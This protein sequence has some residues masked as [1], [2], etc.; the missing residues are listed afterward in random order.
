MEWPP[1]YDKTYSPSADSEYWDRRAETMS[2][3]ERQAAVLAKLGHQVR[4]TFENSEFYRE[5]WREA[6]VDPANIDSL[7]DFRQLPILTK[8]DLRREQE[9]HPPYGRYLCVPEE[10]ILRIHG[11]SGTTGKPTIFGISDDDWDR[12]AEAHARILWSAGLRPDDSVIVAAVF[13]AYIGSWGALVGAERLGAKCFP[14]GAGA[15]QQTER[16][17]DWIG[18]LQPTALY[19]TPSYALYLASTARQMGVDP[20]R[21]FNFRL[22]FFSGEPGASIPSTRKEIEEAFGCYVVDQGSMAEMTP[23]MT[24]S[25]CRHMSRGMHLWDD[26]VYAELLDPETRAPGLSGGEAVPVYTH[27]ERTSQPMIRYWSGDL[28]RWDTSTCECG[29]TYTTLPD[30]LSGRVDDMI[31][32]RGQSI[33]PSKIEDVLRGMPEFGGEFRLVID[34]EPGRM[35]SLT[36]QAEVA[37]DAA[38]VDQVEERF[39]EE[40][41]RAVGVGQWS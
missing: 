7:E 39:A 28:A 11:T 20:R 19:G 26:I 6:G 32:V 2:P 21:D 4:Y 27:L 17:V 10:R 14:F 40:L 18:M 5:F 36:V 8:D 38:G 31:I 35:D 41:R 30:G 15:P 24:N 37:R 3:D 23:W 16:A 29:R 33:F 25:G 34:R 22:M 13:S 1:T 12:I 9:A